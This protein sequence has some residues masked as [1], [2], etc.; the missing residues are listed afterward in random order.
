MLHLL[1]CLFF[2]LPKLA[3]L[4]FLRALLIRPPS[5]CHLHHWCPAS[6]F[7]TKNNIAC[8]SKSAPV[9][10]IVSVIAP[11]LCFSLLTRFLFPLLRSRGCVGCD[12][13]GRWGQEFFLMPVKDKLVSVGWDARRAYAPKA[14][15][16]WGLEFVCFLLCFHSRC[17]SVWPRSQ[18]AGCYQRLCMR[19]N[20][21][22]GFFFFRLL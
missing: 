20:D 18:A 1:Q 4:P 12:T 21:I 13:V 15:S 22:I 5:L 8:F 2:L 6:T 11:Y 14:S 3:L 19:M 10:I 7:G 9:L 17:L 16:V